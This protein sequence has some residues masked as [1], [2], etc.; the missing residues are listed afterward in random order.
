[1]GVFVIVPALLFGGQRYYVRPWLM[2][3]PECMKKPSQAAADLHPGKGSD[4]PA[5]VMGQV[6]TVITAACEKSTY[7][8]EEKRNK[9][10][11]EL[12]RDEER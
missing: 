12:K 5:T 11:N 1:M 9:G 2:W 4:Q 6:S 8:A 7:E 3:K 10:V